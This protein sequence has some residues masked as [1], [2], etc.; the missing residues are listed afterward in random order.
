MDLLVA[1]HSQLR[2]LVLLAGLATLLVGLT[3]WFGSGVAEKNARQ[4]MLAYVI[5]F[6][7]Q[8]LLGLVVYFR[9]NWLAAPL[10]P[11]EFRQ[12][13]IE[14]PLAMLVALGVAHFT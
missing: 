10:S 3:S 2:W 6:T 9:G 14:H 5:V 7:A 13:K 12:I 4:V 1:I 8:V 11:P